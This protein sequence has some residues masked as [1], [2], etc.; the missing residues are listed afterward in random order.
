MAR[1]GGDEKSFSDFG[2]NVF[3][4]LRRGFCGDF[5]MFFLLKSLF[6]GLS[7]DVLGVLSHTFG[8]T[9]GE[10]LG[11]KASYKRSSGSYLS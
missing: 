11:L 9:L 1:S 3:F 5:L 7:M 8:L 2:R 6:L 4:F 10:I